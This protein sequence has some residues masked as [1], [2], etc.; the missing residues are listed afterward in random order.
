MENIEEMT[1]DAIF[2]LVQI[3]DNETKTTNKMSKI[4]QQQQ[5]ELNHCHNKID[6]LE[7]TVRALSNHVYEHLHAIEEVTDYDYLTTI[8]KKIEEDNFLETI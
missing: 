6:S 1:A 5:R 2:M 7:H 3:L 8:C 4:I